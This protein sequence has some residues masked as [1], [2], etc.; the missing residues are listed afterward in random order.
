ME[1]YEINPACEC[2]CG[3]Q[4]P[5]NKRFILGHNRRANAL[6]KNFERGYTV[7]DGTGCWNW[8]KLYNGNNGYG[9]LRLP[10]R[11]TYAHR[12]SYEIHV[13]PIPEG[14]VID[15]LCRNRACVNPEHL[16]AVTHAENA[17]RGDAAKLTWSDVNHIRG[18]LVRDIKAGQIASMYQ[19][20]LI[21]ILAI[22]H[23]HSWKAEDAKAK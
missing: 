15:H 14:L 3:E 20:D 17:R 22:Q 2:G 6:W 18:L 7:D 11:N 13:G 16:E 23:N 21:T 10:E 4:A 8:N 5:E 19:V 12:Y 9:T 1:T